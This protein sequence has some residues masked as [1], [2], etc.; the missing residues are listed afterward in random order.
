MNEVRFSDW[1]FID[2]LLSAPP[3][4]FHLGRY[5]NQFSFY[6]IRPWFTRTWRI[7]LNGKWENWCSNQW[8]CEINTVLWWQRCG[9]LI[10]INSL[11][12]NQGHILHSVDATAKTS[13]HQMVRPCLIFITNAI[14]SPQAAIRYAGRQIPA[15]QLNHC[16]LILV[17]F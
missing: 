12:A 16:Y 11:R 10:H 2:F 5:L 14:S 8:K 1:L 13:L 6:S 9:M 7:E 4:T 17:R 15:K 3:A